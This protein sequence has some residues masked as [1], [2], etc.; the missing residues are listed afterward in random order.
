MK[1]AIF[2]Y[3]L[4]IL[5]STVSAQQ[6]NNGFLLSGSVI[7]EQI[8]KLNIQ[9]D[10]DVALMA[11]NIPNEQKSEKILHFT[12][13]EALFENYS[14]KE[15]EEVSMADES[16]VMIRMYEPDNKT[17]MDLKEK[18]VIEQ[19]DFMSRVFLI[20]SEMGDE[21]WKL[22]GSQKTILE[23]ACHEAVLDSKEEVVHAWFTSEIP[24][25]VGP[26]H[27]N[28]LPGLVLALEMDEGDVLIRAT[29]VE[30]KPVSKSLLQKP[31]KG[32]KVT[33]EEFEAI[34]D[35]KL[36]EMGVET[37]GEGGSHATVVIKMHQ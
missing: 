26:G 28:N 14:G 30:L 35:E 13:N 20:E 6:T 1:K 15:A 31:G 29:D 34:R 5:C 17:Y 12:E 37:G 16:G 7:Y 25:A 19:Q 21:K 36:K 11:G 10:G 2:F 23:F 8:V 32:K 22:T 18:K 3:T 33:R 4:L 9:L 24:V 27:Y